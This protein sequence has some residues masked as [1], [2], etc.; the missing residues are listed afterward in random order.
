MGLTPKIWLGEQERKYSCGAASLKYAL[1]LLGFCPREDD[2]RRLA[3]TTWR[4]T[5]TRPLMNAARR[6][7]LEPKLRYFVEDEWHEARDWLQ[8]ELEAGR[9]VIL[10]V[11]GF[12]HYVVAVQ[13]L[14]GKVVIIDPEGGRMDG[15]AY[16][17]VVLCGDRR[18]KTWWLSGE[19][20]GE[21]AAFRGM[22]LSKGRARPT[23]PRLT[24]SLEAVE[25]YVDGR[26]WILDEYLIDCVEIAAAVKDANGPSRPL[27]ALIRELGSAFMVSS[28]GR[29]WGAKSSDVQMLKAHVEDMAVAAE[30]MKLEVPADG[31]TRVAADV[32]TLLSMMLAADD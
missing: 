12:A 5:S 23:G 18:L 32:A 9:P 4:G 31:A 3:R 20:D 1:C 19:E 7:G 25:R 13:T 21:L 6:F 26:Q 29:W 16:A 8:H 14:A 17:D 15:T 22:S 11:E 24:F 28:V 10:D 2:L 27:G 30:A